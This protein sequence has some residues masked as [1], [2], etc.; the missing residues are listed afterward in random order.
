MKEKNKICSSK[1]LL[2]LEQYLSMENFG[3]LVYG[4]SALFYSGQ[5][6]EVKE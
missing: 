1:R 6:D 3:L 5:E 4:E 2:T